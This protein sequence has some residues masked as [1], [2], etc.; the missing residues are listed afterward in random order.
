MCSSLMARVF[1]SI[2]AARLILEVV[3]WTSWLHVM[4]TCL[5]DLFSPHLVSHGGT[6]KV[7]IR[8]SQ[9]R[10]NIPWLGLINDGGHLVSN[11]MH[12]LPLWN[13]SST[14]SSVQAVWNLCRQPCSA[15]LPFFFPPNVAFCHTLRQDELDV[16]TSGSVVLLADS[17]IQWMWQ[18]TDSHTMRSTFGGPTGKPAVPQG[19]ISPL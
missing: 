10:Q 5:Q 13:L 3:S 9:F 18:L 6:Q 12:Y 4:R 15:S 16:S 14:L 19:N 8:M 17:R 2:W 7:S 11:E 1:F